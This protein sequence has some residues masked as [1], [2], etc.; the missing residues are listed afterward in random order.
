MQ[1]FCGL[2]RIRIEDSYEVQ[3]QIVGKTNLKHDLWETG[4]RLLVGVPF[5]CI[6]C[7]SLFAD[8]SV[9]SMQGIRVRSFCT[10]EKPKT[11]LKHKLKQNYLA[12]S[13][14]DLTD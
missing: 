9:L 14:L 6:S 2:R 5:P 12:N 13:I 3:N 10:Y 7:L 8:G 11:K 1:D 4:I